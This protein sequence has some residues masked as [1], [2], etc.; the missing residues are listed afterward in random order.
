MA[1]EKTEAEKK[2][3]LGTRITPGLMDRLSLYCKETGRSISFVTEK[4]LDVYLPF[5]FL[6]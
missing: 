4:A 2:V 5:S 3:Q 1:V 6:F